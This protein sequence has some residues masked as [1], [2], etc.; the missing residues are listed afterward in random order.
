MLDCDLQIRLNCLKIWWSFGETSHRRKF[1]NTF[2]TIAMT[3]AS[4]IIIAKSQKRFQWS[5]TMYVLVRRNLAQFSLGSDTLW[6]SIVSLLTI[7][8]EI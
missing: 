3:H 7:A 6:V 8:K 5:S 4:R 2:K 1:N